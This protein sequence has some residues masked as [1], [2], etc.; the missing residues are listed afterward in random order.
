[1]IFFVSF[2][3]FYILRLEFMKKIERISHQ[4]Q[5]PGIGQNQ[6]TL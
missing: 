3:F 2:E 6:K 1:M 4:S 5:T